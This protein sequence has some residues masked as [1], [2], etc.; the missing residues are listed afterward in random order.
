MSAGTESGG[1]GGA[2]QAADVTAGPAA[3]LFAGPGGAKFRV[4]PVVSIE[5][6]RG[7]KLLLQ[8]DQGRLAISL[9]GKPPWA[10]Q[11]GRDRRGLWL[12]FRYKDA[13]QRLRWIPPGQFVMGSP[14]NEAGRYDDE[15]QH[16]VTLTKGFWLFD[17]P[18]TQALWE[19][20]MGKNPSR[21]KSPD[22]PVETVSWDDCQKFIARLNGEMPGLQ[23]RLPT[24]AQWE[25]ACRAGTTA[26][27]YSGDLKIK[28]ANNAPVLDEIAWYG[29]N[30]G[31]D[32]ELKNGYDSSGWAEKQYEHRQAGSHP[33]ALKAPNAWGLYDMLG[34]VWEWCEDWYA[35]Y[36]GADEIDPRGPAVG[37]GRVI[38]GGS[39]FDF[40][41]GVRAACRGHG[42][43]G[44]RDDGLGFRC[45]RVQEA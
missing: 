8:T 25:Y 12:D 6:P 29:G 31:V 36:S 18:V 34:N 45:A 44:I 15:T 28:G 23:L 19:A 40:A 27:T 17:A 26:A 10:R 24:E 20:V 11:I 3:G 35:D 30:S 4:E 43:P 16:R 1:Q 21:F 32:F 2:R 9:L 38:R 41:R 37:A 22:R 7:G 5:A 39:W 14:E 33:V 13:E 42:G